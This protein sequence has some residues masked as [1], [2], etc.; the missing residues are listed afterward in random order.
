MRTV[1]AR[2]VALLCSAG[3]CDILRAPSLQCVLRHSPATMSANRPP[4]RRPYRPLSGS[5]LPSSDGQKEIS[6]YGRLADDTAPRDSTDSDTLEPWSPR[7]VKARAAWAN[8]TYRR[9]ALARRRQTLEH[10][11]MRRPKQPPRPPLSPAAQ[12]RSDSL[13]LLRND[14][15]AW[16]RDRLAGG[17]DRRRRLS[18]DAYKAQ[19]REQRGEVARK[20]HAARKAAAAAAQEREQAAGADGSTGR[21]SKSSK[22]ARTV[23][24]RRRRVKK[25]E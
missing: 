13:K 10:K 3:Q 5:F 4:S 11:G 16:M 23:R 25:R 17:V 8:E 2:L 24:P 14:E 18:D 19:L 20:R 9:R 15:D 1:S 12:L 21:A 7:A 22:D 6:F